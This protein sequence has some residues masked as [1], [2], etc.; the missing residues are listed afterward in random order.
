M[1][2]RCVR[3]LASHWRLLRC[4]RLCCL[5]L[6]LGPGLR[7]SLNFQIVEILAVADA[8]AENLLLARQILRRASAIPALP[9]RRPP[10]GRP[11]GPIEA[12]PPHPNGPARRDRGG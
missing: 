5:R 11:S 7:L 1:S 9:R 8:V 10:P 12:A 3:P 2:Q 6:Q 4:K